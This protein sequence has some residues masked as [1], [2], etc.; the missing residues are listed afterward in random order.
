MGHGGDELRLYFFALTD[1]QGHVVDV[2]HQLAQLVGVFVAD[3]DAVASGGNALGGLGHLRHRRHH[4]V[5]EDQ[6]GYEDQKDHRRDN[7]GDHQHRQPELL[8]H[9]M[10]G[11][12]VAHNA[13][14]RAVVEQGAGHGQNVL[15]GQGVPA[16]E[17]S[18]FSGFHGAI[19]IHR[20]GGAAGHGPSGGQL[21]LALAVDKL[22]LHGLAQAVAG[23]KVRGVLGGP[24]VILAVAA[25]A[26]GAEIV[27]PGFRLGLQG[28]AGPAIEVGADGHS[29][30]NPRQD[31]NDDDGPH[32][33]GQPPAAQAPELQSLP[34]AGGKQ[35]Q[36]VVRL[37]SHGIRSP[38]YSQSPTPW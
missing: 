34:P 18:G 17:C 3:L 2:V 23:S 29:G 13:H 30:E 28:G 37:R 11:G 31:Q 21:H 33:A 6:V 27:R 19:H 38:T 20:G 5:D 26:V 14:H 8:V 35:P 9:Q 25:H 10:G 16:G 22:Q 1:L 32:A 24:A 15:A 4:V 36:S 12:D 7:G